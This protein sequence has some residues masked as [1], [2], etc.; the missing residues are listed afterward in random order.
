[1]A[2]KVDGGTLTLQVDYGSG[3]LQIEHFPIKV[4]DNVWHKV[5]II[6]S[7]VVSIRQQFF[8]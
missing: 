3:T 1:M 7:P 8:D 2:L 5:E 6:L 4:D